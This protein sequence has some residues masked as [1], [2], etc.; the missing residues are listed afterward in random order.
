MRSR[1]PIK[2]KRK[3]KEAVA[4]PPLPGTRPGA[5][6]PGGA[7]A[8]AE[9]REAL[10]N[11]P[12]SYVHPRR[13]IPNYKPKK[14][15]EHPKAVERREQRFAK[16]LLPRRATAKVEKSYPL[17]SVGKFLLEP[18]GAGKTVKSAEAYK[19]GVK[20]DF[21]KGGKALQEQQNRPLGEQVKPKNI[22]KTTKEVAPAALDVVGPPGEAALLKAGGALAVKKIAERGGA[23][24]AAKE[25]AKSAAKRVKT[26]PAR[27]VE[28]VKALPKRTA[29]AP[30]RA[31][32]AFKAKPVKST[33]KALTAPVRHPI[34]AGLA[35][36][37]VQA[38][39]AAQQGKSPFIAELGKAQFNAAK[40]DPGGYAA[41]TAG[42]IPGA[43]SGTAAELY[44]VSQGRGEEVV[45]RQLQGLKDMGGYLSSDPKKQQKLAENYAAG[46]AAIG[47]LTLGP[48]I[49]PV[50]KAAEKITEGRRI[51]SR[52]Q[53]ELGKADA[54]TKIVSKARRKEYK[55]ERGKV[56]PE[57]EA[58]AILAKDISHTNPKKA[59]KQLKSRARTMND[60]PEATLIRNLHE[61]VKE[62]NK[63][64]RNYI[65]ESGLAATS[66]AFRKQSEAVQKGTRDVTPEDVQTVAHNL[67]LA[68]REGVSIPETS[69]RAKEGE[70]EGIAVGGKSPT[71]KTL[72][73]VKQEVKQHKAKARDL[74]AQAVEATGKRE[75]ELLRQAKL[76]SLKAKGKKKLVKVS[77][78]PRQ[79]EVFGKQMGELRKQEELAPASYVKRSSAYAEGLKETIEPKR[80][81]GVGIKGRKSKGV[82][83]E[84]GGAITDPNRLFRETVELPEQRANIIRATS[85]I[86]AREGKKV[87]PQ[88]REAANVVLGQQDKKSIPAS[89]LERG[90]TILDKDQALAL[91]PHLGKHDAI[92]LAP[93][94]LKKM[95]N[96]EELAKGTLKASDLYG[97]IT[98][99]SPK[100]SQYIVVD[101][102]AVDQ[103][104]NQA[105]PH[106]ALGAVRAVGGFQTRALL[107]WNPGWAISQVPA[108]GI[109]AALS[110]GLRTAKGWTYEKALRQLP[111]EDRAF[112]EATAGHSVGPMF[113]TK[114][115]RVL[116]AAESTT[117]KNFWQRA[118][119]VGTL[120]SSPIGYFDRSKGNVFRRLV[121]S[122]EIDKITSNPRKLRKVFESTGKSLDEIDAI[123]K[124]LKGKPYKDRLA[125]ALKNPKIMEKA[126][127]E[128]L[129]M[130]GDWTNF[131]K[132]GEQ[133]LAALGLFYP[134]LRYTTNFVLHTFPKNH[135]I[136]ASIA[137][138]FGLQ[139]TDALLDYYGGIPKITADLARPVTRD[140]QGKPTLEG[141]PF[142]GRISPGVNAFTELGFQGADVPSALRLLQ[143]AVG[144]GYGLIDKYP[145]NPLSERPIKTDPVTG[146][147]VPLS[148]PERGTKAGLEML[149]LLSPVSTAERAIKNYQD[150]LALGKSRKSYKG[151]SQAFW[152]A[153]LTPGDTKLMR[154]LSG[155]AVGNEP[156]WK[157][158]AITNYLKAK[159]DKDKVGKVLGGTPLDLR[160][161]VGRKAISIKDAKKR[162]NK[163]ASAAQLVQ[164]YES[165]AKKG[166]NTLRALV[167]R[168]P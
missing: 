138:Y 29:T 112:F 57:H 3:K 87:S 104:M 42:F 101:R 37:A 126:E 133:T 17:G 67:E 118:K 100:K 62:A 147:Q 166:Q 158:K 72:V 111:K 26:Y 141:V 151:P 167:E 46:P 140:K 83:S 84:S 91:Q 24:I 2:V 108:E 139:N 34:K 43:I 94:S 15:R 68:K 9:R 44:N 131:T 10:R 63:Q 50:R 13:H 110:A 60:G 39:V 71:G 30:K 54:R 160:F 11:K 124:Q 45:K 7:P 53:R 117:D 59:E 148:Q 80:G 127:K 162:Y 161:A 103:V 8:S 123:N 1:D 89:S 149:R 19:E 154:T 56:D 168:G 113:D 122:A 152:N 159:E 16:R 88:A 115:K 155:S 106:K 49:K 93:E 35:A 52:T 157:G 40:K 105:K 4:G 85:N 86:Y 18:G 23:K 12:P 28:A 47:A 70:R 90:K 20:Q 164:N 48:K 96:S 150:P 51:K 146:K 121:Q 153:V 107:K 41:R 136:K 109:P 144:A 66:Q 74:T 130:M 75:Q 76:E 33:A 61:R 114:N 78:L 129:D 119:D 128:V 125:F 132:G 98:P 120:K 97:E 116:D 92:V 79:R 58:T 82:L 142:V 134:M 31:K 165:A 77:T 81:Q 64:D 5:G 143:P 95:V 163:A 38:P 73:K 27:K 135:P 99:H 21:I 65:Q 156:A 22:L 55:K 36:G 25:G 137:Y 145:R 14:Q 69:R 6:R 102:R 32:L